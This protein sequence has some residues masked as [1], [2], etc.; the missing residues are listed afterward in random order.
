MSDISV[1]VI[2]QL[3][4][5][6]ADSNNANPAIRSAVARKS[7]EDL[8]LKGY[9][10]KP[11]YTGAMG[12][13]V[14]ELVMQAA[15]ALQTNQSFLTALLQLT[16]PIVG[17]LLGV[18]TAQR[19][20]QSQIASPKLQDQPVSVTLE[21]DGKSIKIS[22][23]DA[24]SVAITAAEL[25]SRFR[26]EHPETAAQ[27]SQQSVVRLTQHISTDARRRRR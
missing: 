26:N 25:E 22:A 21:I 15:Q 18:R 19:A 8:R 10:V 3:L 5:V 16:T 23:P 12:G 27:I 13:D 2:F 4:F 6:D 24:K 7:I 14:Y 17:F 20:V 1:P 9:D 11:V